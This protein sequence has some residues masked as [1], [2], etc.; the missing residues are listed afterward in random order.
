[1]VRPVA[2]S[3]ADALAQQA[4]G[5]PIDVALAQAQ[6]AA[7]VAALRGLGLGV[8]E[9][10]AE[11]AHPDGCFVEDMAVVAGDRALIT[12][13]GAPSRRGEAPSVAAALAGEG[14]E[15]HQ[16]AAP[17][18]LDG[19]DVLR[20]GQTLLVGRSGRTNAAGVEALRAAFG[21]LGYRVRAVAVPAALH[22][23]C[24]LSSPRPGVLLAARGR[25]APAWVEGLGE[26]VWLPEEEAYAANV[27]GVGERV[28]VAAGHPRAAAAL[29]ALGLEP[30]ALAV[31]EI[32][33]ADGS[34]TCLS[35]L[36]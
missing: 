8:R 32:A 7:Y 9:L 14:L 22:L 16:M 28:L 20:V 21:P 30:V 23:K 24:Y 19:G 1:L 33:K 13:S 5:A 11:A 34:L 35:V 2:S 31:S 4:P 6:H 26:V 27:V 3:F 17:A 36:Y 29:A 18:T 25:V 10:P 12:R 15:L